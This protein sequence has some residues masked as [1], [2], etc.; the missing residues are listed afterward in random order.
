MNIK[1]KY[2]FLESRINVVS[3]VAGVLVTLATMFF[4]MS[5]AAAL[6]FW[7]Y[8]EDEIPLL[9]PQFWAVASIAWTVSVFLGACLSAVSSRSRELKNGILN[10]ITTWAGSYLLFGGIALSIADSN[11]RTLLGAPTVSQFWHGFIGDS[12]ALGAGVLGGI[13]GT[14]L[15]RIAAAEKAG[16]GPSKAPTHRTVPLSKISIAKS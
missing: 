11:L 7:S 3:V 13:L 5:L 2:S 6:G 8:Q 10:S 16:E 4:M 12:I 1:T 14:Y 15:E 9:G